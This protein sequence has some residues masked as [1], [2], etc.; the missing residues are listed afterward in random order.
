MKRRPTSPRPCRRLALP[1]ALI[2]LLPGLQADAETI[3]LR[4]GEHDGFSRLVLNPSSPDGWTLGRDGKDYVLR[5]SNADTVFDTSAVY[6]LIPR[7]RLAD[8][9]PG[10][11]AGSLR[12]TVHC[13]CHAIAFQTGSGRIVIDIADGP[14]APDSPFEQVLP[15]PA[16]DPVASSGAGPAPQARV[17]PADWMQHSPASVADPRLA[18]F[19]R[20]GEPAVSAPATAASL[21][22]EAERLRVFDATPPPS[23]SPFVA[24]ANRPP[25]P[26]PHVSVSPDFD[27]ASSALLPD[28]PDPRAAETEAALLLQLSRAASQGLVRAANPAPVMPHADFA[29]PEP[30]PGQP[31][32]ED[33][34]DP[35]STEPSPPASADHLAVHAWTSIDRDMVLPDPAGPVTANGAVCYPDER[36]ALLG[37][38]DGRPAPVQIADR[39]NGLVG[40]FDHPSAEAVLALA[41]LYLHFGLG[42][43]ARATLDAFAQTDEESRLLRDLA[44]I[45]DGGTLDASRPLTGMAD[46]DTAAALW[47]VLAR[48]DLPAGTMVD[49]NAVLRSFSAL[50]APLRRAL[51]GELANRFLTAGD[52]DAARAIRDAMA[53]APGEAGT[54]VSMIDAR[55]DLARGR[56]AAGEAGL[57]RIANT[58]DP[59]SPEALIVTIRSRID[60]GEPVDPALADTAEALAFERRD[61][62]QA[63][64]LDQASILGRGSA[65]DFDRAFAALDRRWGE[66]ADATGD[67]TT[68]KLFGLLAASAD[69]ASFLSHAF[70]ALP[71]WE[72][73]EPDPAGRLA[74]AQRFVDLGF[75]DETRR[76]LAGAAAET[77][78]GRRLLAAAALAEFDTGR[79]LDA[80]AGLD[81]PAS[82]GIRARALALAGDHRAAAAS[83]AAAGDIAGAADQAWRGADWQEV[84]RIGPDDRRAVLRRFG[85]IA[86]DAPGVDAPVVAQ[87]T[88]DVPEPGPLARN[89]TL[90]EESRAVRETIADLLSSPGA[91]PDTVP[92]PAPGG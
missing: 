46:C 79:A 51:G 80:I 52:L 58:N 73:A 90:L 21:L 19:R 59:L 33:I 8:I 22:P 38:G 18:L 84:A 13:A 39:R 50:P 17:L 20:A 72:R 12:L 1:V 78:D 89:R 31:V 28:L 62:P 74:V 43:E 42:A 71:Q 4:S 45:T 5:L 57:D 16:P 76:A 30:V 82:A 37:W 47:A 41:R 55:L 53:R 65:G 64:I 85:L 48:P 54:T 56:T 49:T 75:V 67:E 26:A 92:A 7:A 29:E 3:S 91:S 63:A 87:T 40:E 35:A 23:A 9:T 88:G 70:A 10:K 60:R 83:L 66:H 25:T 68:R 2:L 61:S 44:A 6:R 86:G 32:A 36:L 27:P 15:A 11:V 24:E 81:D 34:P 77:A 14:P 69:D